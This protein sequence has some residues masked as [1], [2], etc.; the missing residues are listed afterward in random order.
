[1][2]IIPLYH[3]HAV[4]LYREGELTNVKFDA[5][6]KVMYTDIVVTK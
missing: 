2:G 5:D 4:A 1:M 6:R 3:R